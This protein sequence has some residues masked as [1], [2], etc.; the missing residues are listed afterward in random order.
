L[1][2]GLRR[3]SFVGLLLQAVVVA[4]AFGQ[5][6]G[7]EPKIQD[8]SF[9]VEEAYN[10]EHGV[11]QHI[12]TFT[13]MWNSGDWS[14]SF[15]QEWPAPHNWRHQFSYTLTGLHAGGFAGS[16][17]GLGD[18][19]LNYR[20]QVLGS[21]ASRWAFAPRISVLLPTGEARLGRGA[22]GTGIQANL[23]V[24]VELHRRVTTHW[25]AGATF[26]R[27]AQG[28]DGSQAAT[29]GYTLAQSFIY[30]ATPRLNFLVESSDSRFQS[31]V[32]PGRA[33]WLRATYIS[34]G[35]RWAHNRK[36][37]MQIVPGVAIPI[38]VGASAGERG[39][40]LYL[41]FEHPFA[42]KAN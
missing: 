26:V 28:A 27:Q 17:F 19:A 2:G 21:G 13:R 8:N 5:H 12:S 39:V 37:G 40:F 1:E 35:V 29:V 3:T 9:L 25:N 15:T 42:G 41:S 24:S 32:E 23:P 30:L 6:P 18:V 7:R 22:G 16:G 38:G 20:Y 10:Q 11:V 36:S 31:V 33:Q 14:Y 34:P 4:T